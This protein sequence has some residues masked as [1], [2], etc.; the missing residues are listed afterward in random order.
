[1]ADI[2]AD[3]IIDD[4]R[5]QINNAGRGEDEDQRCLHNYRDQWTIIG[6]GS[7]FEK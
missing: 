7:R 5:L 2:N 4:D 1:V 6:S 3:Q